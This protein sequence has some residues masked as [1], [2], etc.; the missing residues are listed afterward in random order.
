MVRARAPL[1]PSLARMVAAPSSR[2]HRRCVC[3]ARAR[4]RVGSI[5]WHGVHAEAG[6]RVTAD[7][8]AAD[9]EHGTRAGCRH[10]ER[11]LLRFPEVAS[12]VTNLG[13]PETATETMGLYQADVYVLFKPKSEWKTR[14]LD[15]L[16]EKMDSALAE[17]PGLDYNFSAPMAMRLDEV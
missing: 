5:S 3:A 14:S 13:R 16:I 17:I 10:L 9:S 11:T 2:G 1:V 8:D 4:T 15:R 6:R 12:V 7:R